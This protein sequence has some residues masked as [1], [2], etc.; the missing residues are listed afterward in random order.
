MGFGRS[1]V[2]GGSSARRPCPRHL[3]PS[4]VN[5][6]EFSPAQTAANVMSKHVIEGFTDSLAAE[7][8]P[9]GVH[10][11]AVELGRLRDRDLQD[12]VEAHWR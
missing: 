8:E 3:S 2:S 7:L 10:V 6:R 5:R 4:A 12:C 1:A 9:L 11:S